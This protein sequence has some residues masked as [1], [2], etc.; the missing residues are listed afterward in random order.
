MIF[1][2]RAS[3]KNARRKGGKREARWRIESENVTY[4]E[5]AK[6]LG[7]TCGAAQQRMAKLRGA[8]G[9]VTWAKLEAF[10]K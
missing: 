5:I 4:A 6:R 1:P 9:A 3:E 10:G 2:G 7:I 8:D